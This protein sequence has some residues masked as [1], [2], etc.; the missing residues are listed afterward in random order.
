MGTVDGGR[1]LATALS[2]LGV[3]RISTV[4][5]GGLAP[6]Y[7]ACPELGIQIIH[8]RHEGAAVF[9][10]DAWG[11]LTRRPGVC[12]VTVGPGVMNATVGLMSASL[13]GSPLLLIAGR[14]N[15]GRWD[16]GAVQEVDQI[17]VVRPLVKW[18][19]TVID[20]ARIPEYVSAAFRHAM[21]GRP[22][23]VFLE[24]P[25]DVLARQ[26]E[27][28]AA[29]PAL[30]PPQPRPTG[31]A[32]SI[33][34]AA[35]LLRDARRPL[36]IAGNGVWYSQGWEEL[37][38]VA[39]KA[40]APVFGNRMGRGSLPLDHPLNFGI[41]TPSSNPVARLAYQQCDF[42]LLAG[43]YF[44]YSLAYG[45]SPYF[46]PACRVVQIDIA[47]EL[48]GR[49]RHVDVGIV[50]DAGNVLRQLGEAL[51]LARPA[52]DAAWLTTLRQEALATRR[53]REAMERSA[54]TPIH[55]ARLMSEIRRFLGPDAIVVPGSGDIDFWAEAL[56]EPARPDGYLRVGP[57]GAL[58]AEIP[59]A[60][61]AKAVF[62]E[63]QVLV[64]VGDGG[65]GYSAME[66]ETAARYGLPIV[67]VIGN[68]HG[69][70][71]I[72][73]QQRAGFGRAVG[74]ELVY[75]PYE[76]M[77][78]ALGGHGEAVASPDDIRP[79]LERAFAS[80]RPAVINVTTASE[81]SPETQWLNQRVA[82]RPRHAPVPTQW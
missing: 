41:A 10:A 40:S 11:R 66:M 43:D 47:D 61:A 39:E 54:A 48:V 75:R 81:P 59:Y 80:G 29:S 13:F 74:T 23:P 63:R 53:A 6:M 21:H 73:H 26:V 46:P 68:D 16:M 15:T 4:S 32:V 24:F 20:P 27:A 14:A 51:G 69:W 25:A 5:G 60:V 67:V 9:M 62:P 57:T 56:L 34:R 52:P 2:E 42:A 71:M 8:N 70:S 49:N 19:A 17:S 65:F 12:A 82:Q 35:S 30:E 45:R 72:S 18:A 7:D 33:E 44:D 1:L 77:V 3:K 31:D 37:R 79:A 76:R 78:E 55:P 36:I 38:A 58:G 22:G 28:G 50:G 64:V